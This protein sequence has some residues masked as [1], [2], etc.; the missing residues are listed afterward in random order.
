MK[1]ELSLSVTSTDYERLTQGQTIAI[2]YRP[3]PIGTKFALARVRSGDENEPTDA[4]TD[5][6]VVVAHSE[7][8]TREQINSHLAALLATPLP[9]L[10]ASF[11]THE[12]P[13]LLYMCAHCF[14][15]KISV[16]SG[17]RFGF[18]PMPKPVEIT[19][20]IPL[21]S[22]AAFQKRLATIKNRQLENH[23]QLDDVHIRLNRLATTTPAAKVLS[24]QIESFLYGTPSPPPRTNYQSWIAEI[25]RLGNFSIETDTGK[26]NWQAGTD[27]ENITRKGLEFL[28]FT[29]EESHIGGAGGL[30]FF[31]SKPYP[32]IGECKAGKRIPNSAVSQLLALG[33]TH[34]RKEIFESSAKLV[35]GA[36]SPTRHMLK[37]AQEWNVSIVKAMTLQKLV[38][39]KAKYD[40][41]I[42]LF[43]LRDYL[44]AG[45]VDEKIEEYIRKVEL[46]IKVRAHIVQLVKTYLENSTDRSYILP[47]VLQGAYDFS[48]PPKE[49]SPGEL[50]EILIKLSSPLAGYL[51]RV[52]ENGKKGDRFYYLRDL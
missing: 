49:L 4:L 48:K 42:N 26:S 12:N 6:Y 50:K 27:F 2:V 29:I 33:L 46:E 45:Q 20:S 40:G 37:G 36:G 43:E 15:P 14:A 47:N 34:L 7:I 39:L 31:C 17:R 25:S 24:Q 13:M 28:G 44:Q 8:L 32:L 5:T 35:I 23:S 41:A 11:S 38:E 22:D 51:G 18:T 19:D 30:D 9:E 1:L 52:Q 21:L 16:P 10:Q 3:Y